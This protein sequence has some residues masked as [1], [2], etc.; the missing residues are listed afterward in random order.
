[1]STVL[2]FEHWADPGKVTDLRDW[3]LRSVLGGPVNNGFLWNQVQPL[4]DADL[5]EKGEC[6][7]YVL[8]VEDTGADDHSRQTTTAREYRTRKAKVNLINVDGR[9]V[10]R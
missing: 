8:I 9:E 6:A 4:L 10:G 7:E 5:K 1:M 3:K 2:V